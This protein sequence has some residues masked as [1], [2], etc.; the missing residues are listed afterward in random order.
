MDEVAQEVVVVVMNLGIKT[1]TVIE[2]VHEEV[3]EEALEVGVGHEEALGAEVDHEDLV[4]VVVE[5][6]VVVPPEEK[7]IQEVVDVDDQN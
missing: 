3:L 1:D 4:V 6:E 5:E 7:T 2:I